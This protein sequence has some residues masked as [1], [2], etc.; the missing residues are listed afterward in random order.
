MFS[1]TLAT[2]GLVLNPFSGSANLSHGYIK[3][4]GHILVYPTLSEKIWVPLSL[5][6]VAFLGHPSSVLPLLSADASAILSLIT[7]SAS[8]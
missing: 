2:W 7:V 4:T 1:H 3:V 6:P 8:E 5:L